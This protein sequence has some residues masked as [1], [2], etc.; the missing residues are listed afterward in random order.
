VNGAVAATLELGHP[1]GAI[2]VKNL[3]NRI[4][5]IRAKAVAR[6]VTKYIANRALQ[7]RAEKEGGAAQLFAYVAGNVATAVSEQADLRSW[8]TLP[9][10]ILV[11]RVLLPPG[12]HRI[13]VQY[14]SSGGGVAGTRELG[15]VEVVAGRTRF[16]TLHTNM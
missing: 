8:Q 14:L 15:E 3:Q 4:G 9:D 2:A 1:T 7:K 11:G 10:R 16:F 5:R 12:R 6:A 13:A